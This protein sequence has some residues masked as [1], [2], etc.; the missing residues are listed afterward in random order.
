[1]RYKTNETIAA[2][3]AVALVGMF[4]A[5]NEPVIAPLRGTAAEPILHSLHYENAIIFNL[6]V[7]FLGGVI[8][9]LLNVLIPERRTRS[10]LR[11]NLRKQYQYFREDGFCRI[12]GQAGRTTMLSVLTEKV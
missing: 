3:S 4:I 6:C 9:W 7:G 11:D 5:G 1:M 8:V 10:I 2:L 12:D